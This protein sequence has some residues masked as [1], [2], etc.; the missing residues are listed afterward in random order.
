MRSRMIAGMCLIASLNFTPTTYA[1]DI[2]DASSAAIVATAYTALGNAVLL[3]LAGYGGETAAFA[4][5]AEVA[6]PVAA[7]Y[8]GAPAV[9][10]FYAYQLSLAE[11][12]G[13]V[14]IQ[15]SPNQ[16]II[17]EHGWNER[18]HSR[19]YTVFVID[20]KAG[21]DFEVRQALGTKQGGYRKVDVPDMVRHNAKGLNDC[22]SE[23]DAKGVRDK[24]AQ[25]AG[26]HHFQNTPAMNDDSAAAFRE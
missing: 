1:D 16:I 8:L 17:A 12:P 20:K 26:A 22:N 10:G 7:S 4:S 15:C 11:G 13:D 3:H 5:F 21:G 25:Y 24:L 18:T 19:T 14:S 9:V 2:K 6:T 23:K